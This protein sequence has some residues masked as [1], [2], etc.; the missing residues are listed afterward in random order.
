MIIR[1]SVVGLHRWIYFTASSLALVLSYGSTL[2]ARC[3]ALD[4]DMGYTCRDVLRR[5]TEH[6]V[7]QVARF[8][9]SRTLAERK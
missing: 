2:A 3:L 4:I 5:K 8:N 9:L 1:Y 6:D 7:A